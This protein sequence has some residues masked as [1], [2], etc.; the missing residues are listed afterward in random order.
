MNTLH[1]LSLSYQ[2][3]RQDAASLLLSTE[4]WLFPSLWAFQLIVPLQ[5]ETDRRQAVVADM[6]MIDVVWTEERRKELRGHQLVPQLKVKTFKKEI[7]LCSKVTWSKE[8]WE[9]VNKCRPR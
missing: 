3:T 8:R 5:P 1:P 6:I 4:A 9:S 2:L 7:W